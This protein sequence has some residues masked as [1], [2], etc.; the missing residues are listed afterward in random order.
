MPECYAVAG[1]AAAAARGRKFIDEPDFLHE[2]TGNLI[3]GRTSHVTRHTSHVTR[4]TSHVVNR[5]RKA[6]Y[7]SHSFVQIVFMENSLLRQPKSDIFRARRVHAR[8][9]TNTD[10]RAA[11]HKDTPSRDPLGEGLK[12][13]RLEDS[14]CFCSGGRAE[15]RREAGI[16]APKQTDIGY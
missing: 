2:I 8:Y 12:L 1:A 13:L 16:A 7:L 10:R 3:V 11:P 6:T 15:L 5:E 14:F 4:H 9:V